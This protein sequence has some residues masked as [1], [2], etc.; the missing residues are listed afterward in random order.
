MSTSALVV[1][2]ARRPLVNSYRWHLTP[3]HNSHTLEAGEL[4]FPSRPTINLTLFASSLERKPLERCLNNRSNQVQ[5]I[6]KRQHHLQYSIG[7]IHNNLRQNNH[8]DIPHISEAHAC[9]SSFIT[10]WLIYSFVQ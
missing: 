2:V 9:H 10:A 3:Q 1:A 6:P 7:R 4:N 5:T 8:V